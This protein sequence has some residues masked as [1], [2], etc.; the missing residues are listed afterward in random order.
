MIVIDF[1]RPAANGN[2]QAEQVLLVALS[3]QRDETQALTYRVV[4]KRPAHRG[5]RRRLIIEPPGC[6]QH[7][8]QFWNADRAAH[9][10][11]GRVFGDRSGEVG[12]SHAPRQSK[13]GERLV[14]VLQEQRFELARGRARLRQRIAGAIV[15]DQGDGFVVVLPEGVHAGAR[16]V[17]GSHRAQDHLGAGVLGGS[18]LGGADR[19]VVGIAVVIRQ[20]VMVE[21]RDGQERGGPDGMGPGEGDQ[22]VALALDIVNPRMPRPLGRSESGSRPG[23]AR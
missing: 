16:I 1:E 20:V 3:P 2:G 22:G 9:S 19:N 7:P 5:Q 18:V 10:R 12:Q 6:L 17:A 4:Q 11:T 15:G 21:G 8:V 14:L 13:P 23:E